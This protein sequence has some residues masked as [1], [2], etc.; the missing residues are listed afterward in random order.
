MGD[1]TTDETAM[2]ERRFSAYVSVIVVVLVVVLMV[3]VEVSEGFIFRS[4]DRWSLRCWWCLVG[5][6]RD[7]NELVASDLMRMLLK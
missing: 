4:Q 6:E 1:P 7:G 5:D 3:E 2:V